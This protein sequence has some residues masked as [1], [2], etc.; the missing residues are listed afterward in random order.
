[1]NFTVMAVND[2]GDDCQA[3]AIAGKIFPRMHP[4]EWQKE[5]ASIGLVETDA[6]V[7]D[8]KLDLTGAPFAAEFDLRLIFW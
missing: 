8:V 4:L 6:I 3:D 5:L 7:S 1:M 2:R